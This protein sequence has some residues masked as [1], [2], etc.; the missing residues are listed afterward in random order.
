MHL[1]VG[2]TYHEHHSDRRPPVA[3]RV[4]DGAFGPV[5]G[6]VGED[7]ANLAQTVG[8]VLQQLLTGVCRAARRFGPRRAAT[9]AAAG[10]SL[11]PSPTGLRR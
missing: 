9:K 7:L 2:Q 5:V 8:D 11:V 4:D 3:M 6:Q 10:P 1:Q